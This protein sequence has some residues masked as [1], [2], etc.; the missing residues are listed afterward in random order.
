MVSGRLNLVPSPDGAGKR[1][2]WMRSRGSMQLAGLASAGADVPRMS[3]A[4]GKL[5]FSRGAAQ[6][7]LTSGTLEDLQITDA[8]ID[9]PR[10][11][12]PRLRASAQGNL[13]SPLLRRALEEQGLQQL[14]GAV[15]LEAEARGEAEM[16]NPESWRVTARLI[17]AS[18]PLSADLPPVEKLNGSVRLASG[19]LRGLSLEGRWLGGPV[20]IESR[21]AGARGV[22][23]ANVSGLADAAPLL[24]LLGHPDATGRVSGQL[25]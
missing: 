15:N 22:T 11:G 24:K 13:K 1:V 16:R 18:I 7:H 17:D 21:R 12:A 3:A 20:E 19:E 25:A 14:A 6:L 2:D 5:E 8:R 4:D 9:W 10:R 23:S